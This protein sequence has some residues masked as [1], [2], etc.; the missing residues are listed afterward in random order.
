MTTTNNSDKGKKTQSSDALDRL[1]G[2]FNLPIPKELVDNDDKM[3]ELED[4]RCGRTTQ[5]RQQFFD[6]VYYAIPEGNH[7]GNLSRIEVKELPSGRS[8]QLVYWFE[9]TDLELDL[10]GWNVTYRPKSYSIRTTE[11]VNHYHEPF[12]LYRLAE[13][14]KMNSKD[15]SGV[16]SVETYIITK[17]NSLAKSGLLKDLEFKLGKFENNGYKGYSVEL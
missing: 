11:L 5:T 2:R 13:V 6:N 12:L 9:L 17:L 8:L 15:W 1:F 16:H 4:A 10:P 7:V 3:K 14:A